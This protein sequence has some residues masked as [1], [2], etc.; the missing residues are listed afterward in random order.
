M[1]HLDR[2]TAF[3]LTLPPLFWAGNAV[4]ARML[5]GEVPPLALSLLRWVLALA[6]FLPF[7]WRGLSAAWPALRV[8]WRDVLWISLTGV[9]AYNSLQYVAVQT[10]S[11]VNVTLIAAATPVFALV[12]GVLFFGERARGAQWVGAG[13]S[14]AG[15]VWV[16]LR[17]EFANVTRLNFVAGDLVM[18]AANITWAVYTWLLRKRRPQVPFGPFLAAQMLV[19]TLMILPL[20]IGEAALSNATIHW[21]PTAAA[22]VLYVALFPSLLAYYCWDRGVAR[23]GAVLPVHFANLTPIFAALLSTLLLGEPPQLYHLVGLVA[24][25]AGIHVANRR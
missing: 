8:A 1:Q 24:I 19:G 2:N 4:L 9:A 20:A 10:S 14:I 3:L 7:V 21:T 17:G 16:L 25:V 12:F 22:V 23:V 15:V 13:L 11:A 5:V 18:I 6:L